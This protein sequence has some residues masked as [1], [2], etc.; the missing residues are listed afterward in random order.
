MQDLN[1]VEPIP[2]GILGTIHLVTQGTQ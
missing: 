1:K 2:S